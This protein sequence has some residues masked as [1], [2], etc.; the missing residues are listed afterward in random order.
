MKLTYVGA[1]ADSF[2]AACVRVGCGGVRNSEGQ[3][4]SHIGS[5]PIMHTSPPCPI[6]DLVGTIPVPLQR[7]EDCSIIV[8]SW[9]GLYRL[10]V[11][12][13]VD[14]P[15]NVQ[16]FSTSGPSVLLDGR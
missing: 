5:T 7:C 2:A 3:T 11:T 4:N 15:K 8:A 14:R 12:D 1:C 13:K 9:N 6:L 16:R 10:W